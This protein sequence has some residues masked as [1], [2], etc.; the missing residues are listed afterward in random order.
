MLV[1]LEKPIGTLSKK[2]ATLLLKTTQKGNL[3]P[4]LP[5]LPPPTYFNRYRLWVTGHSLGGGLAS[6]FYARVRDG[7]DLPEHIEVCGAYTFGQPR[8]ANL[9]FRNGCI[10]YQYFINIHILIFTLHS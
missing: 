5:S 1:L 9:D 7:Q 10:L 3:P 4:P 2:F 6:L 8:V